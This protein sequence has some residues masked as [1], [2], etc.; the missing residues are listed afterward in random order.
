MQKDLIEAHEANDKAVLNAFGLKP[1]ATEN[2]ILSVLFGNFA[3][4]S[5]ELPRA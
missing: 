1:S 3:A 2:E 5:E 4:L